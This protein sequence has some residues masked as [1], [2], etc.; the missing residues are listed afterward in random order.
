MTAP[1][2]I[3]D[4]ALT[5]RDLHII[6]MVCRYDGLISW[7]IRRRFWPSPGARSAFFDRLSRLVDAGF[8]RRKGLESPT[9]RGS[10]PSLITIGKAAHPILVEQLGLASADLKRLRHAFV[11]LTWLHEAAVRDFRLTLELACERSGQVA[12][13]DWTNESDL[14]RAPFTVR[15]EST[16]VDIVPDGLFTLRQGDRLKQYYVEIDRATEESPQRW[17]TRV[18]AYLT[19]IGA[20]PSPVLVVVPHRRRLEQIER[21]IQQGAA[22]SGASPGIFALT[23]AD[24]VTERAILH[25]PIWQVVGQS[26]CSRLVPPLP[27]APRDIA[28]RPRSWAEFLFGGEPVRA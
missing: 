5:P 27:Q 4:L 16:T 17:K 20:T 14:R 10:G 28:D 15:L 21:W 8:L 23:I 22:E 26:G 24:R 7:Q 6:L 25:E 9:G 18:K 3:K 1:A 19:L 13:D 2:A 11:P 12:I